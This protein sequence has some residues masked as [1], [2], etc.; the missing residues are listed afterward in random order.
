MEKF[1]VELITLG[2]FEI[3]CWILMTQ[4]KVKLVW[5][6]FLTF[7]KLFFREILF[8]FNQ[9]M[10][11]VFIFS[12]FT[13]FINT[14]SVSVHLYIT[15]IALR[16]NFCLLIVIRQNHLILLL[17]CPIPMIMFSHKFLQKAKTFHSLVISVNFVSRLHFCSNNTKQQQTMTKT[18]STRNKMKRKW[19]RILHFVTW[20]RERNPTLA[21]CQ[22]S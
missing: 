2:N 22:I 9:L 16:R 11:T 5:T 3:F 18:I 12:F 14:I 21:Q 19:V 7:T 1:T 10:L 15:F 6:H 17:L 20:K 13:R 4:W 8:A